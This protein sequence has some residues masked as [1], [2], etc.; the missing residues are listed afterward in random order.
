MNY[1]ERPHFL[2]AK[3]YNNVEREIFTR[4]AITII[5]IF[6]FAP[7]KL[8]LKFVTMRLKRSLKALSNF[9]EIIVKAD[10]QI[11]W[12]NPATSP[13]LNWEVKDL[14]LDKM[15]EDELKQVL[16]HETSLCKDFDEILLPSKLNMTSVSWDTKRLT[17]KLIW[18]KIKYETQFR[19]QRNAGWGDSNQ[20]FQRKRLKIQ[21]RLIEKL[22][23]V[24]WE[25]K[26]LNTKPN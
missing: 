9:K 1:W 22:G 5:F 18:R 4:E 11:L 17:R 16:E 12:S 15:S 6:L 10:S 14:S 3:S 25:I 24:W 23:L 26:L 13:S 20:L 8:I 2:N 21:A 7:A 19:P